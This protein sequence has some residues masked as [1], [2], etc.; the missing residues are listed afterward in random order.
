MAAVGQANFES[1]LRENLSLVL[2]DA[3]D[4]QAIN[5]DGSAPN[6]AGIF[7]R[8]T[9]PTAAPSAVSDF[10]AF[11]AAHAGGIDGLWAGTLK[12]VGIVVG[13]GNDVLGGPDLP[14]RGELQGR[15]E[16]QRLCG[17]EH[18]RLVDQQADAGRGDVPDRGQH[19]AGDPVPHGPHHDERR[20]RRNADG[21]LS[22][23][24]RDF[25]LRYLFRFCE[26]RTLLHD[27]RSLG[28]RDLGSAGR[29]RAGCF[30]SVLMASRDFDA[31]MVPQD[32]VAALGLVA[33]TLYAAQNVSTTATL[34]VREDSVVPEPTARAFR[35]EA[36]GH[37]TCS[38]TGNPIWLWTDDLAGCPVLLDEA[39]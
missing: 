29:L 22:A 27:A 6:L 18:G 35:I 1:I 30:P 4:D 38:P 3:L 9:A 23:L 26:R 37:F 10:D 33:G 8:L 7:N 2:S 13:A 39:P 16:R 21:G 32:L 14:N 31:S 36:G 17:G 28:R 24:E 12:D 25:Y 11:A 20:R 19:P 5:G 15:D 34:F